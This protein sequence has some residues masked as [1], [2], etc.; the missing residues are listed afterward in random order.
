LANEIFT[1]LEK[2][3][4]QTSNAYLKKDRSADKKLK[5]NK[6]KQKKLPQIYQHP[7]E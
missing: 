4:F 1:V 2:N 6:K 7:M 3:K 5:N